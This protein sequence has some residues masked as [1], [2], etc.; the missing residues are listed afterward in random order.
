MA[1]THHKKTTQGKEELE[2]MKN[3]QKL[4]YYLEVRCAMKEG[5]DYPG[6]EYMEND[7]RNSY[8][9][10]N[11]MNRNSYMMDRSYYDNGR[12]GGNTR[13]GHYPYGMSGRR[14]YDDGHDKFM[15]DLHRM[16]GMETDPE[17]R[18]AMEHVARLL[19]SK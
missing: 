13:F 4:M 18:E 11:G 16:M 8:R 12:N 2:K 1:V 19:E 9:N 7:S 15:S 6:S 14:Y 17:T 3:L 10:M 5:G